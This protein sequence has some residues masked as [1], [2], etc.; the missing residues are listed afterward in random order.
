MK[1]AS[2]RRG[3]VEAQRNAISTMNDQRQNRTYERE[4]KRLNTTQ[5][6]IEKKAKP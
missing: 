3:V 6:Y 2:I 4:V 1:S 5:K